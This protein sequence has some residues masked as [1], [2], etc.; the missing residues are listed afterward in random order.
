MKKII[1]ITTKEEVKF[2]NEDL[3]M[4]V[5][6]KE[7]S[8][9]SLLSIT[10]ASLLH[11]N[12]LKLIIFTAY[13]MAKEEFMK[14]VGN[15][16]SVFYLEDEKNITEAVEF[17]TVIVQ[18]GNVDLFL[19]IISNTSIMKDRVIFVK[20]IETINTPVLELI[21]P[22]LFMVSGDLDL[23]M[24]QQ[25]FKSMNYNTKIFTS[26]MTGEIIPILEKYQAFMKNRLG[27]IFVAIQE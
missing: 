27:D 20:N 22:Y 16:E 1:N 8:G 23:N 15:E 17:Q 3:P 25:D 19:K 12:G 26:Q 9:A 10:I 4:L 18:S 5:H 21:K 13:P 7:H 2:T 14:Q 11:A 6:G 24:A